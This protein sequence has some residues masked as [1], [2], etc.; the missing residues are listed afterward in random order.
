M[1]GF[2]GLAEPLKSG[3]GHEVVALCFYGESESAPPE[4]G[5]DGA[6][7]VRPFSVAFA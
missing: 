1:N 5:H 3:D 2:V 7:K 6:G 4:L